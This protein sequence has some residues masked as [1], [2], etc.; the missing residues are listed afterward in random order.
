MIKKSDWVWM[1]GK[2]VQ[3][4]DAK[5]PID[6]HALHYASA[7]F[8]GIRCYKTYRRHSS[9]QCYNTL[10]G[11]TAIFRLKDHIQRLFDSWKILGI[12]KP[13]PFSQ[14][15]IEWACIEAVRKNNLE[16]GY[17]RP[18]VFIGHK[19][20]K[21]ELIGEGDMGLHPQ[22]NQTRVA[23]MVWPWGTYLG[24]EGLE[25][26]VATKTVSVRRPDQNSSLVKAKATANYPNSMRAKKEAVDHGYDEAIVLDKDGYVAEGSAMNIFIVKNQILKTPPLSAPILAGI[27]RD[28]IIKLAKQLGFKVLETLFSLEELYTADEAF[29]TGTAAE[30]CP[31][32]EAD[33][34]I[35]GQGGRGPITEKL[36]KL[37][38][39]I[40]RSRFFSYKNEEARLKRYRDWLTY[41]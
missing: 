21:R 22:K 17:I 40:I 12:Y 11:G 41:V 28:T 19:R 7:V 24:K 34:R 9:G 8:E 35:I 20:T 15:N 13:I 26:G 25:R 4:K 36:Q 18:F 10:D 3:G 1:D 27:T 38:F 16:E 31:V 14:S 39:D 23:I 37:Y 30:V 32:R 5:V 33:K 29:Y 2:F 6:T